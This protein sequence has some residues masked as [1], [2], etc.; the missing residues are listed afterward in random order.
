PAEGTANPPRA[1]SVEDARLDARRERC[2]PFLHVARY[3][4]VEIHHQIADVRI[5]GEDLRLD[6]RPLLAH[7]AV[8]VAQDAG[9]V[10]VRVED[11]VRTPRFG[12]FDLGKVD[13]AGGR[14]RVD[15]PDQAGC[16]LAA[17]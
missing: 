8:D 12:H 17:D 4:L 2:D 6:V 3:I 16:Y 9:H 11:A 1:P 13:R 5:G 7:D 15:E 10:A 14:P